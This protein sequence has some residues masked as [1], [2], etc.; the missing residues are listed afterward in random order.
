MRIAFR[1]RSMCDLQ[2]RTSP[3]NVVIWTTTPW[4]LPANQ[5][6]SAGP[7]VVYELID[8]GSERLVLAEGLR[9]AVLKR[10]SVSEF[11]RLGE[12]RGEALEGLQLAHPFYDRT[13]PVVLGDHVTLDAGT[14]LVH[15][16]PGHGQ[17]DYAVGMKYK[18]KIDNP[19]GGD[20]RYVQ[21]TPLF[22]GEHVFEANKH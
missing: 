8:T 15:T 14:G 18:L 2:S 4:T 5:A 17:E 12:V 3:T 13:V 7:E 22:E 11:K 1:R 19:V 9:P 21:G 6:V 16:A 10:A 20:G